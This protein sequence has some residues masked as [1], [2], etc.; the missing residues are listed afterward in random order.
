MLIARRR[1]GGRFANLLAIGCGL[2]L[3]LTIV[4]SMLPFFMTGVIGLYVICLRQWKLAGWFVLGG[5]IGIAPLLFY[6]SVSFGNP[7]L[8]ANMAGGYPDTMLQLNLSNSGEK[9]RLYLA[10]ITLY[11]P[12]VWVGIL[13]LLFFLRSLRREQIVLVALLLAQAF[14]VLNIQ[15]HGGCHYGPRFLLPAMPF[16]CVGLAGFDICDRNSKRSATATVV[17]AGRLRFHQRFGAMY[18]DGCDGTVRAAGRAAE[19]GCFDSK[20]F[21]WL[22][23]PCRLR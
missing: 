12:I 6:N 18:G 4:T 9:V 16:L 11:V 5:I 14:Q 7:F 19:P 20:V 2:L 15:S 23:L 3:G 8:N 21:L 13:G 10:E 22:R 17:L 1:A